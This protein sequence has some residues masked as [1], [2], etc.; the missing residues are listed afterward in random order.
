MENLI[1]WCLE[2]DIQVKFW[3]DKAIHPKII[4][5]KFVKQVNERDCMY[6]RY[7]IDSSLLD[8][9]I[10]PSTAWEYAARAVAKA[11]A[12]LESEA[13]ES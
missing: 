10:S 3:R 1:L 4:S 6:F 11:F 12:E 13:T 9:M 5:M 2:N 8:K 7:A